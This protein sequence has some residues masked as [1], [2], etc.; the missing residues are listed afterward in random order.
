[1]PTRP[2]AIYSGYYNASAEC[3]S[4]YTEVLGAEFGNSLLFGQAHQLTVDTYAVQH[5][6]GPHP[7]KSV[8][9]HLAGLHLVLEHAVK[10]TSVP[11]LL[12]RLAAAVQRWPHFSPPDMRGA[13]MVFDIALS[14]S[15]GHSALVRQ[16][17]EAIWRAWSLHQGAIAAFVSA[18]IMSYDER[19]QTPPQGL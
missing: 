2:S 17:A 19:R 9:V 6:G 15:A 12:Q 1:M 3:W 4:V 11:P 5:A 18:H 13:P 16:W 14:S 10:P 8:A 7:D